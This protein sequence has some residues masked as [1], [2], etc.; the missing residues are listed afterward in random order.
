MRVSRSKLHL[1]EERAMI[2]WEKCVAVIRES[3]RQCGRINHPFVPIELFPNNPPGSAVQKFN[4]AETTGL[5]VFI[6][7]SS[8]YIR[9]VSIP[10]VS[11]ENEA[12]SSAGRDTNWKI[13]GKNVYENLARIL[14]R[15]RK[16]GFSFVKIEINNDWIGYRKDKTKKDR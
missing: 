16:L 8:V 11:F 13:C 12:K 9:F 4:L 14:A 3:L 5:T 7:F 2:E 15:L 1:E 10:V 6:S